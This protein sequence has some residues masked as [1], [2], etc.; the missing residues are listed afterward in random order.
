MDVLYIILVNT[1]LPLSD[2]PRL[3]SCIRFDLSK[4]GILKIPTYEDEA[5][6]DE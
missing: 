3:Q 4:N 2:S 1:D 6:C 5:E